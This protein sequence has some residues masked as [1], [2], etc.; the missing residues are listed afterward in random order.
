MTPAV[1]LDGQSSGEEEPKTA[2][3]E[4]TRQYQ[5]MDRNELTAFEKRCMG[6]SHVM[7]RLKKKQN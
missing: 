6:S 4:M 2:E 1:D 7:Q 3:M 5:E